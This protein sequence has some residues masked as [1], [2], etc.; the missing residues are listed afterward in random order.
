MVPA[1]LT[2]AK[3]AA[4][5]APLPWPAGA[6]TGVGSL[7]FD[8]A[9]AAASFVAGELPD[10]PHVPE[11]P[12]RGPGSD[13]IGRAA[14][15]LA[16]LHADYQPSGWR[17]VDRPSQDER[18]AL[19][20]LERDLDAVGNVTGGH[21]GPLKTQ[22]AGP[23]TLAAGLELSRGGRALA[24]QGAVRDL[25]EALAEGV[26]GHVADLRRRVPAG[27]LLVQLDEP[28]LPAV[29]RGAVPTVSGFG[30]LRA[31]PAA[32]AVERL[33]TVVAAVTAAG[34]TPVL[35]CCAAQPPVRLAVRAGFR[36]VSLDATQAV[37]DPKVVDQ[38]GEAVE[39][40]VGLL[41]GVVPA[42]GPGSPPT[43]R[44]LARPGRQL[45]QALGQPPE[46][47]GQRVVVT[48]A[49]GLAGASVG[50]AH[51]AYRLCRQVAKALAEAPDQERAP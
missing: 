2:A 39:A 40:G 18:R 36:A 37:G 28:S 50:W 6:A 35:H 8:D 32:D 14:A 25:A 29:L 22:V 27:R 26:A 46:S 15:L 23:L 16:D 4:E 21:D 20:Y 3:S 34:A 12:G 9:R 10:L 30:A 19:D 31:I 49:C 5:P 51:Q 24:D 17:L 13:L 7:P 41:L 38:L 1:D 48:P 11:L 47:L 44:D 33:A 43:V 45:W 42:L